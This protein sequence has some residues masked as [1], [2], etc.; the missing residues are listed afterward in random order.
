[1]EKHLGKERKFISSR[2]FISD[3]RTRAIILILWNSEPSLCF[4]AKDW[5]RKGPFLL[6]LISVSRQF[7]FKFQEKAFQS[8]IDPINGGTLSQL[9]YSTSLFIH[10]FY[11]IQHSLQKNWLVLADLVGHQRILRCTFMVGVR[12][13][14][15]KNQ[16]GSGSKSQ[17]KSIWS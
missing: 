4:I 16:K 13:S 11:C 6:T 1:M 10:V 5:E 9:D 17:T 14:W 8:L 2:L 15:S 12:L 3:Q 7:V